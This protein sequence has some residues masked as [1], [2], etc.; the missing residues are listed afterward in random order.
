MIVIEARY[1]WHADGR[2]AAA[3]TTHLCEYKSTPGV[4]YGTLGPMSTAVLCL[5]LALVASAASA[6]DADADALCR[7]G[8]QE[9]CVDAIRD[10]LTNSSLLQVSAALRP[11]GDV[12]GPFGFRGGATINSQF[13]VGPPRLLGSENSVPIVADMN[14]VDS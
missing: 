7:A 4:I 1:T 11:D 8:R 12:H 13:Y 3:C 2:R 5:L 6:E 10:A 9:A 14:Y